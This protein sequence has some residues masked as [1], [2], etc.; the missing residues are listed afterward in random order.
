MK[1]MIDTSNIF[2]LIKWFNPFLMRTIRAENQQYDDLKYIFAKKVD[3]GHISYTSKVNFSLYE[4]V[5]KRLIIDG[6]RITCDSIT[7][8]YT[9]YFQKDNKIC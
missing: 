4:N 2:N 1:I 9:F 8:R 7:N 5:K 3:K 6:L